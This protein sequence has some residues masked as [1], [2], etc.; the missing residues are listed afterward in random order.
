MDVITSIVCVSGRLRVIGQV[1]FLRKIKNPTKQRK[2]K[3]LDDIINRQLA[4]LLQIVLEWD[5]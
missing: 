4:H 3:S 2:K 1:V 5:I